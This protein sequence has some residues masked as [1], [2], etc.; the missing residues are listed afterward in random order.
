MLSVTAIALDLCT[1]S[2]S[3]GQSAIA[4]TRHS[5]S[6]VV[7]VPL[8]GDNLEQLATSLAIHDDG[9]DY[10]LLQ[11]ACIHQQGACPIGVIALA[12]GPQGLIHP[13]QPQLLATIAEHL[14]RSTSG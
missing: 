3:D 4:H 6:S 5:F 10:E 13:P 1:R 12:P 7:T 9:F 8:C 11:L 2:M 14:A